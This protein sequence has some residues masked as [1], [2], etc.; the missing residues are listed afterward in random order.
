MCMVRKSLGR[1]QGWLEQKEEAIR[2][3]EDGCVR[4]RLVEQNLGG[5]SLSNSGKW[6]VIIRL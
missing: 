2:K 3:G 6:K 4:Y 1:E 5:L